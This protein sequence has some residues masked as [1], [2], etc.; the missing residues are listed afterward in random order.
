MNTFGSKV[1]IADGIYHAVHEYTDTL[2]NIYYDEFRNSIELQDFVQRTG[3]TMVSFGMFLKG[4]LKCK[5]IRAPVMRVCVD[6]V[7]TAFNELVKTL[8]NIRKANRSQRKPPCPCLFCTNIAA[9]EENHEP[10]GKSMYV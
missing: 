2:K 7:E 5:C 8:N 9:E 4:A 1:K 10:G 3:K 6:E